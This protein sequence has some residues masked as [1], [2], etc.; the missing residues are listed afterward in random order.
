MACIACQFG[1]QMVC[2][3]CAQTWDVNDPDPPPCP[4]NVDTLPAHC[5]MEVHEALATARMKNA[6]QGFQDVL[7]LAV[8]M[9]GE[10]GVYSSE[11][12]RASAAFL[13]QK[14]LYHAH[15]MLDEDQ[16]SV[17]HPKMDDKEPIHET[18]K[19]FSDTCSAEVTDFRGP[20]DDPAA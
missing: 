16:Y 7:I 6:T 13:L 8:G 3:L 15:G 14:G 11:M 10:L 12:S 2:E 19:P 18:E 17:F 1:D 4:K 9:D 5:R 20:D